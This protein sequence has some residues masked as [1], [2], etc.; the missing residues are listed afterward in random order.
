MVKLNFK[1]WLLKAV[2]KQSNMTQEQ[3]K[4]QLWDKTQEV[5]NFVKEANE[6]ID[7]L[8]KEIEDLKAQLLAECP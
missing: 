6:K 5:N 2:K 7:A 4:S 3:I 8:N 1:L